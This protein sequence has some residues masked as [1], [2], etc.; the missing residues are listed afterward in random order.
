MLLSKIKTPSECTSQ[1]LSDFA[2]F[3][4]RAGEVDSCGL[5]RRIRAA[6]CLMFLFDPDRETCGVSSLKRPADSYRAKVFRRAH[7]NAPPVSY[8]LELGW[9]VVSPTYRDKKLSRR[10]VAE[11]LPKAGGDLIYATTRADNTP[12]RRTLKHS[13]FREEGV[14][15]RSVRQPC[16]LMLFIQPLITQQAESDPGE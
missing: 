16:D 10:L 11:L 9:I 13:G 14:S 8:P 15:Y 12:M 5:Q 4:R 2:A 3:V 6:H 7:S 1:E